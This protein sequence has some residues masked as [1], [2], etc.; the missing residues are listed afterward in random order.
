MKDKRRLRVMILAAIAAVVTLAC[1]SCS[2]NK[3]DKNIYT[4]NT[5]IFES[6]Q[7]QVLLNANREV[8]TAPQGYTYYD[9]YC[10]EGYKITGLGETSYYKQIILCENVVPVEVQEIN[11][12]YALPGTPVEQNMKLTMEE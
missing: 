2:N 12:G 1:S 3:E 6:G 8:Y 7:H 10:P 9:V 4:G 11:G 5:K